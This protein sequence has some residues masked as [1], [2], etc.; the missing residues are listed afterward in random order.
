MNAKTIATIAADLR[1]SW[2]DNGAGEIEADA[3]LFSADWDYAAS[4]LGREL[5]TEEAREL[6]DLFRSGEIA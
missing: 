4:E 1:A 2:I 3:E 5:T 6:L